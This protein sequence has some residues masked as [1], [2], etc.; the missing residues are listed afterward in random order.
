MT[1]PSTLTYVR[2]M[3]VELGKPNLDADL[4]AQFIAIVGERAALRDPSDTAPHTQE[5]RGLWPGQTPLVLKPA[6][7]AQVSAIMALA[8]QHGIAI[9]PQGGNTGLVGGSTP[10][11]D[12]KQIVLSLSRMNA[13]RDVDPL[14]NTI[15]VEAGCVLENVQ[16]AAD[17]VNRLFPLRIG[18]QGSCQIGGNIASNAGGTGVLAY[19]NM[20]D[21]VLGLEVV[22]PDGRIWN[23]L[24]R[25]KKNN[26]GYDLK[27]LFI[28]GEGTLGVVT[29]AVLKLFPKPKGTAMALVGVADPQAAMALFS[30]LRDSAGH[31][32]TAFELSGR[33][34]FEFLYRHFADKHRDPLV[35]AHAWYCLIEVSSQRD[36]ADAE[37]VLTTALEAAFEAG[38]VEDAA[39]AA[40]LA[41]QAEFW[42]MR[43]N[44]SWAQKPEGASIKHDISVPVTAIPS[45]IAQAEQAVLAVEPETRIVCFGHM[46]DGN[47]HYNLS[48]PEGWEPQRFRDLEHRFHEAVYAVIA[49]HDG[50]ISAEHG[51]GR[52]KMKAIATLKA[53]TEMDMMVA[54]KRA[55]DP[56]GIMNP[57]KLIDP[58][59]LDRS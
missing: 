24:N 29:A 26:T 43:E 48:Q 32:L 2:L 20:R 50:S 10:S 34:P 36:Q 25:L 38:E 12:G 30:R 49:D 5:P 19:G 52:M 7:T 51:I 14:G 53:G 23:G 15:I 54:I 27:H 46:G 39:P 17:G 33:K 8:H 58:D 41:Q 35:G 13:V 45:F 44:L 37:T 3:D 6:T 11:A 18:S 55:L 56:H 40:N 1:A 21:L 9:V 31:G 4:M 16:R 59:L 42:L 57:G 22:L 47:L 28:A